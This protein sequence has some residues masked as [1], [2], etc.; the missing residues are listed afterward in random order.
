MN[1]EAAPVP[2][3]FGAWT[4]ENLANYAKEAYVRIKE[5][6]AANEQLKADLRYAMQIAR[7][8]YGNT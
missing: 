1:E 6:E 8:S 7:G 2:P 4:H 5:L 3:E